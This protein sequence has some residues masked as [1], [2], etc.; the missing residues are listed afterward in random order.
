MSSSDAQLCDMAW[1]FLI[2]DASL[3][4]LENTK[5]FNGGNK[6]TDQATR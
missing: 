1:M 3:Q 6:V 4:L 5:R 2:K